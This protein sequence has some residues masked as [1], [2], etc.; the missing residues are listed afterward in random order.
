MAKD[1]YHALVR[2][3]LENE[4][5]TITDD[6]YQV[7]MGLRK[8][9]I[10]LGAERTLIGA[11]RGNEKIAVEIKTFAGASDLQDMD[12]ASGQYTRYRLALSKTEPERTLFLAI[13]SEFY[14]MFFQD[15]FFAELLGFAGIKSLVYDEKA[16]VIR[17]WI[18]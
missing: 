7:P 12:L 6:P 17:K 18:K 1:K 8:G 2:E 11:E 13:P 4:G 9:F 15:P 16:P 3:A 5:W 10:D 14:Q